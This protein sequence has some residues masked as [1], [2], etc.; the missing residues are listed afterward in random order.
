MENESFGSGSPVLGGTSAL[1]RAIARRSQGN[2]LNSQVSPAAPTFDPSQAVQPN[3]TMPQ[4]SPTSMMTAQA[5]QPPQPAQAPAPVNP[6]VA[7]AEAPNSPGG[8]KITK[9]EAEKITEALIGHQKH[10][11]KADMMKLQASL[12]PQL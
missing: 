2:G 8:A 11:E 10:L 7:A 1:A 4:G 12:P 6:M 5:F 9:S 3:P